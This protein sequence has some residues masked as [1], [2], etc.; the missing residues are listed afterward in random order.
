MNTE[1]VAHAATLLLD[2]RVLITGGDRFAGNTIFI[3]SSA[4]MFDPAQGTFTLTTDLGGNEMNAARVGHT[5]T[6]IEDGP[7]RGKVLIAGG[8]GTDPEPLRFSTP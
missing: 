4:E 2:G 6:L 1:R 5:A 8:A 3:L 7:A